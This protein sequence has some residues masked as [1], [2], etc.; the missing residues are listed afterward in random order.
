MD[1]CINSFKKKQGTE[2][3]EFVVSVTNND[4]LLS[5]ANYEIL[6]SNSSVNLFP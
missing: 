5:K 6:L 3:I 4:I 1:G 2:M